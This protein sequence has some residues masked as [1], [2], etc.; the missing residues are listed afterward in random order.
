MESTLKYEIEKIGYEDFISFMDKQAN[1]TFPTLLDEKW[2]LTFS[3]K[4]Y[5]NAE[6]CFC[7]DNN[8]LV[9]VIAFY[10]NRKDVDFA[11]IPHIYVSPEHRGQGIFAKMFQLVEKEITLRGFSGIR[12]QVDTNN[13]RA[14]H[15][16]IK[17]GFVT[18][19]KAKMDSFYMEKRLSDNKCSSPQKHL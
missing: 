19:E 16:Y 3:N 12:L 11:Y 15:A 14:Q 5:F 2:R 17:Q 4:L 9:G 13:F 6:F 10:A 1:D 8:T 7:R 18:G